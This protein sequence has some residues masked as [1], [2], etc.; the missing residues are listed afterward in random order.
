MQIVIAA[1][2]EPNKIGTLECTL[3]AVGRRLESRGC[4]V[5][6]WF[7]GQ[8]HEKVIEQFGLDRRSL[9]QNLGALSTSEARRRWLQEFRAARPDALWLNFFPHVGAFPYQLRRACPRTWI[10]ASDRVSRGSPRVHALKRMAKGIRARLLDG[11]I[12]RYLAVSKFIARR[13]REFDRI[14]PERIQVVY[15]GVDLDRF[16]PGQGVGRYISAVCYMRPEKGV[17][18]LLD[19]LKILKG[20]GAAPECRVVGIG[21]ELERYRAFAAEHV[22]PVRFLGLRDDVPSILRDAMVVVVPS[23]WAEACGNAALEGQAAGLP[24]IASAIGGLPEVIEP[25]VTGLLFP[26]GDASALADAI[27]ELI[28]D[29]DRRRAM[30]QAGR[31]RI[32]QKFGMDH[33]TELICREILHDRG[34]TC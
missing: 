6:Y 34:Q 25:G 17:G 22:L 5:A 7:S 32:E 12:D 16:A 21:P 18:V 28:D 9:K 2:L 19:A 11:C 15:N 4:T 27:A 31:R 10:C 3:F 23:L 26:P 14:A 20:R 1:D 13:M 8:V 33:T 24:V 30:G 29:P